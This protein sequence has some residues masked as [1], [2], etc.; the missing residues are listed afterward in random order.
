VAC[1]AQQDVAA[2]TNQTCKI[3]FVDPEQ[4]WRAGYIN[5][6][7]AGFVVGCSSANLN[8][9]N[10]PTTGTPACV[11]LDAANVTG[12]PCSIVQINSDNSAWVKFKSRQLT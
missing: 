10:S 6:P 9:A 5:T 1:I 12:G 4:I 3:V 7:A 11:H 2:G 8:A